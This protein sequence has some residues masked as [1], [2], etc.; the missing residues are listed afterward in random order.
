[1]PSSI[2]NR[3]AGAQ[4]DTGP[5]TS[6]RICDQ[7]EGGKSMKHGTAV[8]AAASLLALMPVPTAPALAEAANA[9][10]GITAFCKSHDIFPAETLGNC[11]ALFSTGSRTPYGFVAQ[12]CSFFMKSR[13][14]DF[15][16][17]YDSYDECILDGASS[18][19]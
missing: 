1:V 5:R 14:D 2:I 17:V 3:P 11:V 19:P 18:L 10:D 13:A 9:N 15:Y 16:A 6:S 4:T 8:L 7:D 12:I